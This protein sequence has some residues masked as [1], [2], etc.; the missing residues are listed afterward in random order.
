M[1]S[2]YMN[3]KDETL[4]KCESVTK[5]DSVTVIPTSQL[6]SSPE[7]VK[8]IKSDS[9]HKIQKHVRGKQ[10]LPGIHKRKGK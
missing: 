7:K 6:L 4:I 8:I 3:P 1:M 9:N 10:N 5:C 2:G